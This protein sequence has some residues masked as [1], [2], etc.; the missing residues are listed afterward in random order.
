MLKN[1]RNS[2]KLRKFI[3]TVSVATAIFLG[4]TNFATETVYAAQPDVAAMQAEI[5]ELKALIQAL[6]AVIGQPP[7][8][9][10]SQISSQQ[11]REIAT[12][13]LGGGTAVSANLFSEDGT[14][15]FEV[16]VANGTRQ[17]VYINAITAAVVRTTTVATPAP[18][19]PAPPA[20]TSPPVLPTQNVSSNRSV[21]PANPAITRD[22]AIQIA[23]N[24]MRARG[25]SGWFDS[26]EMDWE[27]GQWVW[28]VEFD[29]STNRNVDYE[30]YINVD[31]GAIV[32]FRTDW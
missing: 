29:S 25:L 16:E 14:P 9:Q 5:E 13:F 4:Y 28:E 22:R 21:R 12:D 17:M 27:M 19:I 11:A 30:W 10:I 20:P 3:V 15:M 26:I 8:T 23:E 7:A 1:S 31:T 24:D 2:R 18:V 32:R 6:M